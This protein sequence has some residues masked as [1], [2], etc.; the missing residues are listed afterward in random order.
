M[1]LLAELDGNLP[2]PTGLPDEEETEFLYED[3]PET[4]EEEAQ[5]LMEADEQALDLQELES[6]M[7]PH[8]PGEELP[9]PAY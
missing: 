9:P 2:L 5:E 3:L 4:G 1:Q 7:S 6:E 8:P